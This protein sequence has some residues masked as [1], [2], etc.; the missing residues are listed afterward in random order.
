MPVSYTH[1]DV[2]KRQDADYTPKPYEDWKAADWPT[3]YEVPGYR[4]VFAAGIAFA[5]PH[6]ISRPLKTA[7]GTV[8]APAPP[9]TGMP[10]GVMGKAVAV[11]ISKRLKNPDAEAEH[12]LLYTSRCV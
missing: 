12:C 7:N 2:Y 9:R 1:L 6:Q 4:N 5:P 3:T 8:V 11:T 10:S